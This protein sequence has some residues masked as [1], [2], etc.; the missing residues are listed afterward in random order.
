MSVENEVDRRTE[1]KWER[2]SPFELKDELIELADEHMKKTAHAMINAGRG[3]PNWTS[4]VARSAFYLLGRFAVAEAKRDWDEFPGLA[5]MPQPKGIAARFDAFLTA[6][7]EGDEVK[8]LRDAVDYGTRTL[9]FAP[10]DWVGELADAI[11]G[12]HYPV[13]DRMLTHIE[14]VVH[15]YLDLAMGGAP[16]GGWDLFAT[17]GGTAAMCY[18]FDSC[19]VNG[20]LAPG[21]RIAIMTPIFTPYLEIPHLERYQFDV[22]EVRA[23]KTAPDGMHTW[24]YPDTEIEKLTDPSVKALFLVNPSNPPSVM[25]DSATLERIAQIASKENPNLT[26]ITD[27]VYGTF[28]DGFQSLMSAAAANTIGVYSFSKYFGCT[29][30]RLGVIAVAKDNAFDARIAKLPAA[31]RDRLN[32]RYSTIALEPAKL[33]FIDRM[34]ADSRDVALNHTAGLSTPQQ[35]QMALFALSDLLDKDARHKQD[36]EAIIARRLRTL[37]ESLQVPEPQD[38]NAANYYVELDLMMWVKQHWSHEFAQWLAA[39]HEPVDPVFRLAEQGSIVLLNGGGFDGPEWSVRVSLAN[40]RQD[41]Y[42]EIG[43]WLREIMDEYHREFQSR[44]TTR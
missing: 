36:C 27:D 35:V 33:K 20:I 37:C 11:H 15:A 3:N 13:P 43:H 25:L 24:Q 8:L 22:V 30:W 44:T 1:K 42:A 29:G 28:V 10:D 4:V 9:G 16:A 7:P 12:D 34:V 17:E 21:D 2:L 40:L 38:P 14:Q 18:L 6:E 39:E 23:S 19:V 41:S 31:E 26:I 32:K 5:G